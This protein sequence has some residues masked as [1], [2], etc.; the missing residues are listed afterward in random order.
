ME[1]R[2]AAQM[3]IYQIGQLVGFVA[4][5]SIA[6]LGLDAA[7]RRSKNPR[8]DARRRNQGSQPPS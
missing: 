6:L 4:V 3:D 1:S 5:V 2:E 7:M 8:R